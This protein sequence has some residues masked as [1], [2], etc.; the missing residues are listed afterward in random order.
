MNQRVRPAMA[1][2]GAYRRIVG[3][4]P[5]GQRPEGRQ[6]QLGCAAHKAA[7][8]HQPPPDSLPELGMKMARQFRSRIM[9]VG[10]VA[11]ND[12]IEAIFVMHPTAKAGRDARIMVADNPAPVMAR[13]QVPKQLCSISFQPR[14]AAI[15]MEIV[16]QA[17]NGPHRIFACQPGQFLERGP[18]VI[19]R[20]K[21][22]AHRIARR[23]F[24]MQVGDKQRAV[25]RPV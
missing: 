16:P 12:A 8:R 6:D 17:V 7:P 4:Q 5:P 3:V 24:K 21:L 10:L 20:Q 19:G 2:G 18:A 11:Q 1:D 22:P 25:R 15:V 14:L 9:R 23:L 13:G